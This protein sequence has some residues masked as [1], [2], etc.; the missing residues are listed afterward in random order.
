EDGREP[1]VAALAHLDVL[2][3]D[4]DGVVRRD[5][6]EGVGREDFVGSGRVVFEAESDDKR[7]AGERGG[8]KEATTGQHA[9]PPSV[10]AAS[11]IAAR[12]RTSVA[13]RH[14]LPVIAASMSA[15]D[16]RRISD[17]SA[18]P[19]MIWPDWRSRTGPRR[20]GAR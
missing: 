11:W 7:G 18:M 20:A 6:H 17:S 2:A 5:A 13:Q 9:Q 10:L 19:D 15:S 14:T 4:R 16:G 1:G 3:D 12:M 8:L